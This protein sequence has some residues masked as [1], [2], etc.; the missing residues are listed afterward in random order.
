MSIYIHICLYIYMSPCHKHT[1]HVYIAVSFL[2][3]QCKHQARSRRRTINWVQVCTPIPDIHD[4]TMSSRSLLRVP[5]SLLPRGCLQLWRLC[6]FLCG[7]SPELLIWGLER[8]YP[9]QGGWW[10]LMLREIMVQN[11][12]L[13]SK[14]PPWSDLLISWPPDT[15]SPP[16]QATGTQNI[17]SIGRSWKSE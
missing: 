8:N 10:M 11:E 5:W 6:M 7:D 15:F 16:K 4:Y 13:R 14:V 12:Y 9:S 17:L 3:L 2:T 1:A